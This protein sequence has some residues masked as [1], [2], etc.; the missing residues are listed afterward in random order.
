[1]ICSKCNVNGRLV[2]YSTFQYYFCDVCQDEII[3]IKK[4]QPKKLE[5]IFANPN[6]EINEHISKLEHDKIVL[7]Y[8]LKKIH[9]IQEKKGKSSIFMCEILLME[10][11]RELGKKV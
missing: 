3:D 6:E 10:L 9:D 8:K 2:Q 7:S 4:E 1:M 11:Q 5:F